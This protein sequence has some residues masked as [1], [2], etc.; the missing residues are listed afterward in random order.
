MMLSMTG[1]VQNYAGIVGGS[2]VYPPTTSGSYC[3]LADKIQVDL[4]KL[5]ISQYLLLY[6]YLLLWAHELGEGAGGS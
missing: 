3:W 2:L 4:K 6:S 5:K 1:Y